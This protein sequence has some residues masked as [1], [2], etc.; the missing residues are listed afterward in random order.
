MKASDI[1]VTEEPDLRRFLEKKW[2]LEP[3]L[4]V[5][6]DQTPKVDTVL[7]WLG[8][9][10][11]E[12]IPKHLHIIGTDNLETVLKAISFLSLLL[13]ERSLLMA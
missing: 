8:I 2:V 9:E 4:S 10:N 5:L 11:H 13:G 12:A 6:G 7:R 3:K 1:E